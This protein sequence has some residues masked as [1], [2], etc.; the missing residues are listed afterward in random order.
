MSNEDVIARVVLPEGPTAEL[1]ESLTY[2]QQKVCE[3]VWSFFQVHR[4]LPT[5][6][7]LRR[8]MVGMSPVLVDR[9]AWRLKQ[10]P[11]ALPTPDMVPPTRAIPAPTAKEENAAFRRAYQKSVRKLGDVSLPAKVD[12]PV[13]THH[14]GGNP[15]PLSAAAIDACAAI[16]KV[17]ETCDQR[18]RIH[19]ARFVLAQLAEL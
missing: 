14:I 13:H 3:A 19:V 18:E 9:L 16:Q 12:G 11:G 1:F 17:M 2:P 8:K 6:S 15:R 5:K 10:I 7:E 4:A